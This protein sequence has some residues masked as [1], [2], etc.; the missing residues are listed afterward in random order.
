MLILNI[1]GKIEPICL[2]KK[3]KLYIANIPNDADNNWNDVF[4]R[5]MKASLQ[6]NVIEHKKLSIESKYNV[7]D[8]LKKKFPEQKSSFKSDQEKYFQEIADNAIYLYFDYSYEDMPLGGWDENPFDGRFCEEDYSEKII[9]F[10]NYVGNDICPELGGTHINWIYS[11]N[12]DEEI[13]RRIFFS[14]TKLENG[15]NV[16]KKWGELFDNFLNSKEDYLQLDYLFNSLHKDNEYNEYHYFKSYSLCQMLLENT[17][18]TE[19]DWKLPEFINDDS[20]TTE[21]KEKITPV[22]RQ[23]RNKIGHGDFSGLDVKLEVFAKEVMDGKFWFDYSEYS[24]R[25]WI[26]SFV[27]GVIDECVREIVFTLF[28]NRDKLIE[29]KKKNKK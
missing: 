29:L 20:F 12:H 4:V 17:R 7:L 24:R 26:L 5:E 23:I 27:C 8:N 21:Q 3:L 18:E 19:L 13:N 6:H 16:L 14:G 22:L 11:S 2:S 28:T 9:D 1:F 15:I 25:N 10:I